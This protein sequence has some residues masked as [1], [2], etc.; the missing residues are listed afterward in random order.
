MTILGDVALRRSF[1]A[2]PAS[3]ETHHVYAGGLL[4]HTVGVATI[5][6]GSCS[7]IRGCALICC[8]QPP[9]STTSAARAAQAGAGVPGHGGGASARPRPSR[10]PARGGTG[11]ETRR[12]SARRAAPRSPVTTR[13]APHRRGG[14]PLSREPARRPGRHGRSSQARGAS[15]RA[16]SRLARA[17]SWST[18][19]MRPFASMTITA[20]CQS[21]PKRLAFARFVSMICGHFQPYSFTKSRPRSA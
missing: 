9:C 15:P 2:L 6:R 3:P 4:E 18:A 14:A 19:T 1:R 12:G 13:P 21:T 11:R 17:R 16:G 10:P 20:G 5:C 8:W 7:S